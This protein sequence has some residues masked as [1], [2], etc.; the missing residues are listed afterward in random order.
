V[1]LEESQV[2][3]GGPLA[4]TKFWIS[5]VRF[6]LFLD[7]DRLSKEERKSKKRL[8]NLGPFLWIFGFW[9][10]VMGMGISYHGF[11]HV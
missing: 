2:S 7:F 9:A 5:L 4:L 3:V 8:Q 10:Y 6:D 11:T 1:T